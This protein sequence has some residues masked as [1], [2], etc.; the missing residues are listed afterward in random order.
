M[1]VVCHVVQSDCVGLVF[2]TKPWIHVPRTPKPDLCYKEDRLKRENIGRVP[3]PDID[4]QIAL[5]TAQ[6][7]IRC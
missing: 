7:K 5:V 3:V 1:S 6:R 4:H 2:G